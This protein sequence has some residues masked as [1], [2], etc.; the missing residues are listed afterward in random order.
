MSQMKVLNSNI[1]GYYSY[2]PDIEIKRYED[3][4]EIIEETIKEC[5]I[6]K[7]NLCEPSYDTISDN[8]NIFRETEITIGK[9]GH[10]FHA[11]CIDKWLKT[12]DTCPIDKARRCRHRDIDSTVRYVIN[13]KKNNNFGLN[14]NYLKKKFDHAKELAKDKNI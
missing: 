9:C 2:K 7:R 6:C 8:I 1:I 11:D 3:D 13:N 4:K 5:I 14:H 10:L 12:S